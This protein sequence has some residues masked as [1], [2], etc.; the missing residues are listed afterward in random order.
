MFQVPITIGTTFYEV[1]L[2]Y[3]GQSVIASKGD[4][5]TRW[6]VQQ[7]ILYCSCGIIAGIIGGLLGLGGGFILG[8][9]FIG[10]GIHPQVRIND[11]HMAVYGAIMCF[12]FICSILRKLTKP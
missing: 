8:P 2:L 9:L 4:Q 12:H 7:L 10:L 6:R 1:V 11:F 3:K 5:Q